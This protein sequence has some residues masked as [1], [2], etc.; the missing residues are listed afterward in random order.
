[1]VDRELVKEVETG[2][3]KRNE[4]VDGATRLGASLVS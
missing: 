4:K 2:Q 1:M 3:E